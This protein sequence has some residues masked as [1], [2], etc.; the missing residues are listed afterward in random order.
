M[1]SIS[2][3]DWDD[4]LDD[5][6]DQKAVLLIG[7][8][9]MKINGLPVNRCLRDSLF[10]RNSEDITFYYERDGLFLFKSPE[11]K[12]RIARQVKRFYR[13]L[14]PDEA[15]LKRIVQIPFHLIVSLNPDTFVSEAL[16]QY[17]IKHRFHYFQHRNRDNE[18]DEI[19]KP[20]RAQPLVY[21]LFGSK[22]QDDSL[23]LDYDDVYKMLQSAFGSSSLPNKFLRS[24]RE[25]STY[26]F[27]GFQFEKWYSQ[28]LLKF[29]SDSGRRE[30]LISI[31]NDLTDKD[32]HEFVIRQFQIQ[33]MGDQFDFFGELFQHCG[34]MGLLRPLAEES[35][36][37]Q[38]VT[39][40]QRIANSE[41]ADALD[42]FHDA[43]RGRA[44]ENEAILLKSRYNK[45]LED[46]E[47]GILDSRDYR[48]EINRILDSML[49]L[50]K[51]ICP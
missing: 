27:V 26:I 1:P 48:T 30:K 8:E 10:E 2:P 35:A 43:L 6:R 39:I 50:T 3:N 19:E 13:D 7:P 14:A 12:V 41:I 46:Q 18:N 40:R 31:N 15:L 44:D 37:P 49:D 23:I 20:G 9:I 4:I 45:L 22:D 33:F 38:A 28:L 24:F 21:N 51:T 11:S 25:A 5:I 29:L 16:Y 36:C 17:G 34:K 32:T 47:K 42:L